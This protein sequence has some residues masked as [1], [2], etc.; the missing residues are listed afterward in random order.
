MT[1]SLCIVMPVFNEGSTLALRLRAL[2]PLRERGAQLVV[3]DGGSTDGTW[4][5]AT[6]LAD[7]VLL[8]PRG[9]A[10]R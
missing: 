6:A 10:A 4:A 3:V 9:R 7:Q 2:A 5:I 1:A 8:A